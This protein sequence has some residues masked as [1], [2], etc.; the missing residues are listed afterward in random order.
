VEIVGAEDNNTRYR[1]LLVYPALN[2]ARVTLH[3][4]YQKETLDLSAD[5]DEPVI[6]IDD[7][8]VL[9]YGAL[10]RA[11]DRE[12]NPEASAKNYGMYQQKIAKMAGKLQDTFDNPRL[13][14]SNNYLRAKRSHI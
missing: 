13:Q 2:T 4:D 7:R 5:S 12:R 8:A 1:Q 6:P 11:W 9:L 3:I 10:S 14:V